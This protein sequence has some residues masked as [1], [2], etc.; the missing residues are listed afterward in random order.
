V[1]LVSPGAVPKT[2]SGKLQ[3]Y[4]CREALM[5]GVLDPL[6]SWTAHEQYDLSTGLFTVAPAE[7]ERA[8]S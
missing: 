6:A 3:R 2:T 1:T 7:V 5:T 8:A 4:L